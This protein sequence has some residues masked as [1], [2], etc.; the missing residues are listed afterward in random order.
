MHM[1]FTVTESSHVAPQAVSETSTRPSAAPRLSYRG[2]SYAKADLQDAAPSKRGLMQYR[3]VTYDPATLDGPHPS[4][5]GV[6][7]YAMVYRGVAFN[8]EGGSA[9]RPTVAPGAADLLWA[10][11]A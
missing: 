7:S 1:P 10:Q 8:S 5:R 6:A 2:V 4:A 9:T 11:M 3:G